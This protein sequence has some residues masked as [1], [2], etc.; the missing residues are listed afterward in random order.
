MRQA[1]FLFLETN[2]ESPILGIKHRVSRLRISYLV[3]RSH[4]TSQEGKQ[5][6]N[7]ETLPDMGKNRCPRGIVACQ[8]ECRDGIHATNWLQKQNGIRRFVFVVVCL[9]RSGSNFFLVTMSKFRWQQ[10]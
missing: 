8:E 9:H 10:Q 4:V 3:L 5:T 7:V 6:V 1:I 2:K